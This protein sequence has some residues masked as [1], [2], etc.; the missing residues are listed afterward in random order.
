VCFSTRAAG[1]SLFSRYELSL[2]EADF[3]FRIFHTHCTGFQSTASVASS[4]NPLSCFGCEH[5]ERFIASKD[6][7]CVARGVT[8]AGRDEL[9]RARARGG[10]RTSSSG[11]ATRRPPSSPPCAGLSPRQRWAAGCETRPR[12]CCRRDRERTP[13]ST[14]RCTR[15]AGQAGRCP[16]HRDAMQLHASALLRLRPAL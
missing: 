3:R 16:F 7:E 13:R 11:G 12:R 6:E 4:P 5:D 2:L 8:A 14:G 10:P 15:A 1:L 9:A